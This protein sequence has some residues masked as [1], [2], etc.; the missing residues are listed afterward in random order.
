MN[1]PKNRCR[2]FPLIFLGFFIWGCNNNEIPKKKKVE[3]IKAFSK[4][5]GYVRWFHP[6]DEAQQIDWDRFACYGVKTVESAPNSEALKDSLLKLFLPIAPSLAIY[7]GSEKHDFDISKITPP[8]TS[9]FYPVYW[10]H[11]GV[12]LNKTPAN[13]YK[14]IRVGRVNKL[15]YN[16][17]TPLG[18]SIPVSG[19]SQKTVK[20]EAFVKTENRGSGQL[21]FEGLNRNDYR[22]LSAALKPVYF[23]NSR[24]EQIVVERTVMHDDLNIFWGFNIMDTSRVFI[25]N[26]K[27]SVRNHNNRDSVVYE[28]DFNNLNENELRELLFDKNLLFDVQYIND[29]SEN[30]GYFSIRYND[31]NCQL[32][33]KKPEFGESN[34]EWIHPDLFIQLPL[35][36][37]ANDQH[38]YP[39]ANKESFNSLQNKLN[40]W[41]SEIYKDLGS[42]VV[43]W[44][45]IQHF[46]PY[47]D[48]VNVDW[49]KEFTA[50]VIDLLKEEDF[51]S[52]LKKLMA[53]LKDGHIYVNPPSHK[54]VYSIPVKWKW[55]DDKL[56]IVEV[57][58][59]KVG[60]FPGAI[61]KKIAE[62]KAENYFSG[63]ESYIPAATKGALKRG[64][65][66]LSL[67]GT[68]GDSVSLDV[69]QVDG[70][71]GKVTLNYSLHPYDNY[72]RSLNKSRHNVLG[73][74]I[75]YLNLD[76]IT[77]SEIDS[78]MPDLI[79]CKGIIC[80]LRGYPNNNHELLNHLL[81]LNDTVDNWFRIPQI[82]YPD[83]KNISYDG[84]GWNVIPREPHIDT[85]VVLITDSRAI[86]YA[87]SVLA[88]VKHYNLATI[89][90]QPSAGTNGNVNE[91]ILPNGFK[92]R[93]TGMKVTNLDG[94]Q[95]FGV[96]VLPDVYVE[97]T[98]DGVSEG[99]DEF[100]EKALE[101]LNKKKL[102]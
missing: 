61:V 42:L 17:T 95:H 84:R 23:K 99:R 80:D 63:V 41:Q 22:N 83:Q 8:E 29:Q 32:F 100:L 76:Q 52:V 1:T 66:F 60:L 59:E 6:S 97:K 10:Q 44:N 31:K 62:K 75:F 98:I 64:S 90:G 12:K 57:Y 28:N 81:T 94:S 55:I 26:I 50:A 34:C 92:T 19:L 33:E 82:L 37:V 88:L 54:Y 85:P 56:I 47:F 2:I 25:D 49:N 18:K 79:E 71:K 72:N 69:I 13:V 87:E 58:D 101:I 67:L 40:L 70:S 11:S 89:V 73:D 16:K 74:S 86:S 93:F 102:Q 30:N 14:S 48:E 4:L 78:M 46:F 45:V 35:V 39:V 27:L 51:E 43:V 77:M 38:T 9:G 3:N 24:W 53:K 20:L 21:F 15:D 36:L 91:I 7:G 96:G 68:P 65:E 5:Y